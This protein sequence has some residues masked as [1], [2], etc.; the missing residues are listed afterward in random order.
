MFSDS[1][2]YFSNFPQFLSWNPK[3]SKIQNCLLRKSNPVSKFPQNVLE[4]PNKLYNQFFSLF[5]FTHYQNIF[6]FFRKPLL[7]SGRKVIHSRF[8]KIC[9]GHLKTNLTE[10]SNKIVEKPNY[11]CERCFYSQPGHLNYPNWKENQI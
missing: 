10:V 2:R 5:I 9:L 4:F 3:Y 11:D 8:F 7:L 6:D 1:V